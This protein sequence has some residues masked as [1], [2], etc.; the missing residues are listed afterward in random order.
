MTNRTISGPRQL[1]EYDLSLYVD[2]SRLHDLLGDTTEYF[3][4]ANNAYAALGRV[5]LMRILADAAPDTLRLL[6]DAGYD[7][8]TGIGAAIL[9]ATGVDELEDE[10]A[11]L[12]SITLSSVYGRPTK[13]DQKLSQIAWPV[14]YE[15]NPGVAPTF[16]Q[17]LGEAAY[18]TDTQYFAKPENYFGLYCVAADAPGRGTN[19]LLSVDDV[20]HAVTARHGTE[21]LDRL[22][23]PYP[24]RVPS[25]FTE[26]GTDSDVE[27][28]WAPILSDNN[29]SFR[30]RKDTI[31]RALETGIKL[32]DGQND[33]LKRLED[34]LDVLDPLEYHLQPGDALLINNLRLLHARTAFN[35]PGRLLYR[36][37]MTEDT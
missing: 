23:K 21:T 15:P 27:I 24:F 6:Q 22:S 10:P 7:L 35:D 13:T 14:R 25:V 9:H 12:M 1:A 37:R 34:T 28:T 5:G 4:G 17:T 18:H 36:V 30:Y 26:S 29:A 20:V 8:K 3:G 32:S 33:A 11:Q 31:D 19:Q 16:S 2:Y